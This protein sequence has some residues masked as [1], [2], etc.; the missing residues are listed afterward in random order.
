MMLK[1]EQNEKDNNYNKS[2]LNLMI[3][4]VYFNNLKDKTIMLIP[5]FVL[6]KAK[7]SYL[8]KLAAIPLSYIIPLNDDNIS[9]KNESEN[10]NGDGNNNDDE[11]NINHNDLILKQSQ[12]TSY[13]EWLTI[14]SKLEEEKYITVTSN[15]KSTSKIN[16]R[17]WSQKSETNLYD[18]KLL[19]DRLN[20]L[21]DSIKEKDLKKLVFLIRSS[22]MRNLG[23][24]GNIDLYKHSVLGTKLIIEDYI[25]ECEGVLQTLLNSTTSSKLKNSNND[26]N[27][28]DDEFLLSMLIQ[29]R[30]SF[31]RT[32]LVLSGG[33]CFGLIHIGV[34]KTLLETNLLPRIISGSSAGSIIASIVCVHTNDEI[35]PLLHSIIDTKFDVFTD[36]NDER[37]FLYNLSHFLKYGTWFDIIGLTKTMKHFLGDLTFKS[38]YYRTG[39]ILNITVS[40][41]SIYEQ[42]RLL[43]YLTSPDVLIWSAVC[44][45]CSL[46]G[47]FPSSS[48]YERNPQTGEIKKWNHESV[49]FMDGSVDGD[50]P[51]TRL[52]EILN[53]NHIIACQVNPHVAPLLHLS[54]QNSN[55]SI[56]TDNI[57]IEDVSIKLKNLMD[58][59]YDLISSEIIHYL[60]MVNEIG[61]FSNLSTKLKSILI[62]KYSGDITILPNIKL[63]EWDKILSNPTPEFLKD[64]ALRGAQATWPKIGLIRNHCAIELALDSAIMTLRSKIISNNDKTTG[65]TE[66]INNTNTIYRTYNRHNNNQFPT[67]HSMASLNS[68]YLKTPKLKVTQRSSVND[69]RTRSGSTVKDSIFGVNSFSPVKNPSFSSS[70]TSF[71][72]ISSNNGTFHNTNNNYN[73]ND[74]KQRSKSVSLNLAY[75]NDFYNDNNIDNE[76]I[77][78][79]TNI[80]GG[81][82]NRLKISKANFTLQHSRFNTPQVSPSHTRA[83]SLVNFKNVNLND[84]PTPT[85]NNI[86]L[87]SYPNS[88]SKPQVVIGNFD[89]YDFDNYDNYEYEVYSVDRES[90]K[91]SLSLPL[92]VNINNNT[93]ENTK[94]TSSL[95][96]PGSNVGSKE[97]VNEAL[98]IKPF[99]NN[100]DNNT[101]TNKTKKDHHH[102]KRPKFIKNKIKGFKQHFN[103]NITKKRS[104]SNTLYDHDNENVG[105]DDTNRDFTTTELHRS[106]SR[107]SSIHAEKVS[108]ELDT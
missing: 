28:I 83:P 20:N 12:A 59:T 34:L 47:I 108:D 46:P 25:L 9:Y 32:A 27:K 58:N 14:T 23:D 75:N 38:A 10:K 49:K 107:S 43:N 60:D 76:N 18:Y 104:N 90:R 19:Q 62:Q 87:I 52:S 91:S 69:F 85:A 99:I 56:I 21:K 72:K 8:I 100:D 71:D 68:L 41:T 105:G 37:G 96:S 45:S 70:L 92:S 17:E 44:A 2:I 16:F 64:A 15:S 26:G 84:S 73:R 67:S 106:N 5:D 66:N 103:N 94:S 98:K 35:I 11:K 30:K 13:S 65:T 29:T 74:N 36:S 3:S 78:S 55:R 22:W 51:I 33:G 63:T 53:V 95:I 93:L 77:N 54:V 4:N 42:T 57:N 7:N 82:N 97:R 1:V 24:M 48:I 101:S 102:H 80:A 31:G 40:P 61:I 88:N 39:K 79:N 89:D 6:S 50:L 86:K 81:S